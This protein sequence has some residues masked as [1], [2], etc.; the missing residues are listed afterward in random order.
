M[1][2][3]EFELFVCINGKPVRE[4]A[5]DGRIFVEAKAGSTY[6]IKVKNNSWKRIL[7]VISV[8]G[9]DVIT[10]KSAIETDTGYVISGYN[11][12]EIKGFRVDSDREA[13]FKFFDKGQGKGYAEIKGDVSSSGVIGIR[14]YSEKVVP[15]PVIV[16][17]YIPVYVDR[18]IPYYPPQR[19]YPY[20]YDMTYTTCN[21]SVS[22]G[23][24]ISSTCNYSTDLSSVKVGSGQGQSGASNLLRSLNFCASKKISAQSVEDEKPK[25]FDLT[26]G[27]G[28][29]VESKVTTV[30]FEKGDLV[31]EMEIFYASRE[32]LTQMGIKFDSIPEV[33]F[34][35]AF[36]KKLD[37]CG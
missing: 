16:K 1:K 26:T 13:S 34:P 30:T 8:D 3:N 18:P 37:F 25:G 11:N 2:K 35:S 5:K 17:E 10:G 36:N 27:W 29:S 22:D 23:L 12:L 4:Y 19:V 6:S 31:S 32:S 20:P 28:D 14:V 33:S 7:A 15:P 24:L 9:I 21:S